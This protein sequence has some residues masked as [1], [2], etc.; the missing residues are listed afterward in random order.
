M[1]RCPCWAENFNWNFAG[2]GA[3]DKLIF[4]L[5]S[6]YWS[7]ETNWTLNATVGQIASGP[8]DP[9]ASAIGVNKRIRLPASR[10]STEIPVIRDPRSPIPNLQYPIPNPQPLIPASQ[11]V[12]Q[13]AS[14][15]VANLARLFGELLGPGLNQLP[16]QFACC[17]SRTCPCLDCQSEWD[18]DTCSGCG[19]P[20]S[21]LSQG[22][23]SNLLTASDSDFVVTGAAS[24]TRP[25]N[26]SNKV[27]AAVQIKTAL[28]HA[29]REKPNSNSTSSSSSIHL[30]F[31]PEVCL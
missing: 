22:R 25:A 30:L 23:L 17:L 4:H 21:T 14:Q 26:D 8:T 31:L 16:R 2:N 15:S 10:D 13:S 9:T 27:A 11:A 19:S 20:G 29:H 24:K 5:A 1:M 18:T 3:G 7:S 12:S 28:Q 6:S